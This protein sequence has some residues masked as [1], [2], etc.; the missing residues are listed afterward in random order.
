[1]DC[2]KSFQGYKCSKTY[3]NKRPITPPKA[4][5]KKSYEMLAIHMDC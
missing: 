1:M 5:G 2:Q 3:K 4:M